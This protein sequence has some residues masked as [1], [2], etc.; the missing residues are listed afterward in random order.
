MIG[1]FIGN[2]HII[3]AAWSENYE[4]V[5]T[6]SRATTKTGN[7]KIV[8]R[9]TNSVLESMED[10]YLLVELTC[11]AKRGKD[12]VR[13]EISCGWCCIPLSDLD[14]A[15]AP[16]LKKTYSLLGGSMADTTEMKPSEILQRRT[17][18]R[19]IPKFFAGRHQPTLVLQ[20]MALSKFDRF[21]Q[22]TIGMLPPTMITTVAAL[23]LLRSYRTL[24][25]NANNNTHVVSEPALNFFPFIMD[26]PRLFEM[27]VQK[28]KNILKTTYI[29]SSRKAIEMF[30]KEVLQFWPALC[31]SRAVNALNT[32]LHE[33]HDVHLARMP[34]DSISRL[35]E[36]LVGE[37]GRDCPF[38]NPNTRKDGRSSRSK[39][40]VLYTPFQV[41]EVVLNMPSN[42]SA[43]NGLLSYYQ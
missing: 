4:D 25:L 18:L 37:G 16:I 29:K 14:T 6:F 28:T 41:S 15:G 21:E 5:W 24:F 20:S 30:R 39:N 8:I 34:H 40:E 22:E 32:E 19:T 10:V 1:G 9:V 31:D 23:P 7:K 17:G 13:A 26:H 33:G 12:D 11:T 36:A 38:P 43:V 3:P 42:A 2:Q 35:T 27:L